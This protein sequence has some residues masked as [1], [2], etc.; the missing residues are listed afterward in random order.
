MRPVCILAIA[1]A[2]QHKEASILARNET[3]GE[4]ADASE[5]TSEETSEVSDTKSE[6]GTKSETETAT[7]TANE[8]GVAPS[9]DAMRCELLLDV[10]LEFIHEQGGIEAFANAAQ[11]EIA[12]AGGVDKTCIHVMNLRGKFEHGMQALDFMQVVRRFL[13]RNEAKVIVDFEILPKCGDASEE[14]AF[15]KVEGQLHDQKSGLRKGW[16]SSFLSSRTAIVKAG[17]VSESAVDDM[18]MTA[19]PSSAVVVAAAAWLLL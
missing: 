9:S 12:A 13:R 4:A 11:S 17:E 8:T 10:S 19:E 7:A 18:T 5:E 15:K 2:F 14:D 6:N 1:L 3:E 16:L